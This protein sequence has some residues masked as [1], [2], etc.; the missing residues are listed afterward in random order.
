[1]REW[2]E[3]VRRLGRMELSHA[4]ERDVNLRE[5]YAPALEMARKVEAIV[6]VAKEQGM[7]AAADAATQTGG[8]AARIARHVLAVG[9]TGEIQIAIRDDMNRR[10]PFPGPDY[11]M[12]RPKL[13]AAADYV[14][15]TVVLPK[16]YGPRRTVEHDCF[17]CHRAVRVS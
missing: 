3:L 5:E 11:I 16:K 13:P 17:I 6:K 2:I 7:G 1:M 15:E 14:L 9:A 4:G 12:V 8:D 10:F